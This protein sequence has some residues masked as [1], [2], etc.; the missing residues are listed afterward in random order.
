MLGQ[1]GVHL[2]EAP[3]SI[4]SHASDAC[5]RGWSEDPW[6][7]EQV[8]DPALRALVC[9]WSSPSFEPACTPVSWGDDEKISL[10][11]QDGSTCAGKQPET[12]IPLWA[13]WIPWPGRLC[14][15]MEA[16]CLTEPCGYSRASQ[17]PEPLLARDWCRAQ[18]PRR[19]CGFAAF[20][21]GVIW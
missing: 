19:R 16:C 2:E 3:Q 15:V 11:F 13:K 18:W 12:L 6:P 10:L 20:L 5:Q 7:P 9:P 14:P 4:S 21:T 17:A 8:T 1:S